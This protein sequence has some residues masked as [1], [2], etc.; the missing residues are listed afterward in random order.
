MVSCPAGGGDVGWQLGVQTAGRSVRTGERVPVGLD[1]V[2]HTE[3]VVQIQNSMGWL[4]NGAFVHL[5]RSLVANVLSL[6]PVQT[7]KFRQR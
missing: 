2:D 3:P 1:T 7:G 6:A 5:L 4:S